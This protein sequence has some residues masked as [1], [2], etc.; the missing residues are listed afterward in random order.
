M[1]DTAYVMGRILG[2]VV[3]GGLILFGLGKCFVLLRRP[4]AN[5][6]CLISLMLVLAGFLIPMVASVVIPRQ[7]DSVTLHGVYGVIG[8]LLFGL[9]VTAIILAV[10]GLVEYYRKPRVYEHGSGPAIASLVIT[11]LFMGLVMLSVVFSL[12]AKGTRGAG[13]SLAAGGQQFYAKFNYKFQVPG[14]P[15][16]SM[17]AKQLNPDAS[18]ALMRSNP[19]M[20]FAVIAENLGPSA[21]VS[22]ERVLELAKANLQSVSSSMQFLQQTPERVQGIDGIRLEAEG[23]VGDFPLF[24][25]QWVGTY[26]GYAYQ[27]VTRG[28]A[29]DKRWIRTEARQMMERF[30]LIDPERFA[31]GLGT[32]ENFTSTNYGYAVDLQGAGCHPWPTLASDWPEAEFGVLQDRQGIFV[33]LPVVLPGQ[34]PHLEALAQALLLRAG[35]VFPSE[36]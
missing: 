13:T 23:K 32:V 6:K 12:S 14:R 24:T 27:L 11:V 18:L 3:M 19:Q 29:E 25:V 22:N 21:E 35:V 34:Q 7:A 2:L 5:A 26:H 28:R 8:L 36:K 4:T 10:I 15:W 31:G 17:N 30:Q 20:F 9:F 33:V 16:V 1:N